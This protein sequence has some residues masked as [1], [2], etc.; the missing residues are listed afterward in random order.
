MCVWCVSVYV[1]V[2]VWCVMCECVH[3]CHISD[4]TDVCTCMCK[5]VM[6]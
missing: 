1:Y 5:A 6:V 3:V 2:C 4:V